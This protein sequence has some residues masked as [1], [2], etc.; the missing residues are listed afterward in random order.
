MYRTPTRQLH[1][2]SAH[3]ITKGNKASLHVTI[4]LLARLGEIACNNSISVQDWKRNYS[5]R[6]HNGAKGL[7][8]KL[9]EQSEYFSSKLDQVEG[10]AIYT[11]SYNTQDICLV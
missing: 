1:G 8:T 3:S 10:P 6:W 11:A 7:N 5:I 2:Q 9:L 4:V